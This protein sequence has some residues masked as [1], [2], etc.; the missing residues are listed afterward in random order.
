MCTRTS[1]RLK[2]IVHAAHVIQGGFFAGSRQFLKVLLLV[3]RNARP[4]LSCFAGRA[5]DRDV[6]V[7]RTAQGIFGMILR[8][9]DR[10]VVG[11]GVYP[12]QFFFRISSRWN[13]T[14]QAR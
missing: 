11:K 10:R 8:V 12:R 4:D 9:A 14:G 1:L 13:E 7:T 3:T 2:V 6:A 5:T